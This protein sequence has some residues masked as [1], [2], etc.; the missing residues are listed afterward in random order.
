[1]CSAH[2]VSV[3]LGADT[4]LSSSGVGLCDA[5]G[6]IR[7]QDGSVLIQQAAEGPTGTRVL[8]GGPAEGENMN[9]DRL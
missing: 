9:R 1:M 6:S 5:G 8:R 7:T 2:V 3:S 4:S